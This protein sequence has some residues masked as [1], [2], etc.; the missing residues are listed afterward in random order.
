MA[1][2]SV[3]FLPAMQLLMN[4]VDH[5]APQW[6]SA[7]SSGQQESA[8]LEATDRPKPN[9]LRSLA[10]EAAHEKRT[11]TRCALVVTVG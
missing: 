11:K 1:A 2:C 7:A 9:A 4:S 5:D 6:A 10:L 3:N 8:S